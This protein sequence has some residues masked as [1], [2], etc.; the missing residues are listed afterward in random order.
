M[1][2]K[3]LALID[4]DKEYAEFLAQ[5]LQEQGVRVDVFSD[6]NDLLVHADP[7]GY[8]FYLVDLMLPG[9]D[10]VD[11]IKLLRRRTTAGLVVVSGRL[12]PD[13]FKDVI[14]AGADMYLT[15]P[16]QFEQVALAIKAVHRR[17]NN[18]NGQVQS[19]WRLE[20]RTGQ[21]VAPDGARVDLSDIDQTLMECFVEAHGEVVSRETLRQRIGKA[22]GK[23]EDQDASDGL[24]A[25]IYRLRRRIERATPL[26]VPLQSKSRVGYVF[27]APL[28]AV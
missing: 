27:R 23:S 10:G 8:Q 22:D 28:T 9:V 24:N 3:S 17:I 21:L 12:A 25:T 14:S 11:L 1:L 19:E 2:P 4:D 6:S 20:R 18:S 13:V 15:K 5:Y 7:Y 26:L 16:V